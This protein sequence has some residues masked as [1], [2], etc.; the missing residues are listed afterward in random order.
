MTRLTPV[1][2]AAFLCLTACPSGDG[3]GESICPD[4]QVLDAPD[5]GDDLGC[6]PAAC[7]EGVWG[8]Q[9]PPSD[10]VHVAPW[11]EDPDDGGDGSAEKPLKRLR[12]G[13][14]FA[15]DAGG[16]EVIASAGT[17][18]E[19]LQSEEADTGVVLAGRCALLSIIDG[20]NDELL[21]THRANGGEFTM[22]DMTLTGGELGLRVRGGVA[23]NRTTVFVGTGLIIEENIRSGIFVTDP[24]ASLDLRD[25]IVRNTLSAPDGSRGRGAVVQEQGSMFGSGLLFEGNRDYGLFAVMP[26]TRV[27]LVD[28]VVRGTLARPD[29]EYGH[30]IAVGGAEFVG[31]GLLI[32]GNREVGL[33]IADGSTVRLE[34]SEVTDTL[35]G[36]L[37]VGGHG[38]NA[39]G[40]SFW[41]SGLLVARNLAAGLLVDGGQVELHRS[42]FRDTRAEEAT[43]W[44]GRG[45]FVQAG[46]LVADTLLLENNTQIGLLVA[47]ADSSAE[48]SDSIIRGTRPAAD[49]RFGR[50]I[51]VAGGGTFL[52]RDLLVQD[53]VEAGLVLREGA[54][55]L[56]GGRITGTQAGLTSQG[57]GVMVNFGTMR[58]GGGIAIEDNDTAGVFVGDG[59]ALI[60]DAHIIGNTFAGVIAAGEVLL[61]MAGSSISGTRPDPGLGGGV[62]VFVDGAYASAQ[63]DIELDGVSFSDLPGPAMYLMGGE[64]IVMRDCEVTSSGTWPSLPGGVLGFEGVTTWDEADGGSGLLLEGNRFVE[65]PADAI[66]LAGG[67]GTLAPTSAGGD[68]SFVGVGGAALFAQCTDGSAGAEVLD[69]SGAD[70]SCR[71]TPR[72][73]GPPLFFYLRL[74]ESDVVD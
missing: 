42:T 47:G 20:T 17:Y 10:A 31:S 32:Q 15:R 35:P 55:E 38:I 71:S 62:G 37:G 30:G 40:G 63:I 65:L 6:V 18:R 56:L 46:S 49:A 13:M 70:G 22:R 50:G 11:G 39:Q 1:A 4:G 16:V 51:E 68:N 52:G 45:I 61:R 7:G 26:G 60:E 64:R 48:L 41:G 28:S 36:P 34:D 72:P 24:D 44:K 23:G 53:N 12:D 27:E 58:L 9:P 21:P 3:P 57:G 14:A 73:L 25:S 19:N 59:T 5:D 67:Q 8:S 43:S 2:A 74:I 33:F 69:G 29:G 54:A 66:V